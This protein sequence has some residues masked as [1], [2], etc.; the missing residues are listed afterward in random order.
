MTSTPLYDATLGEVLQRARERVAQVEQ[1]AAARVA[2]AEQ[3]ALNAERQAR[4]RQALV[5]EEVEERVRAALA[6]DAPPLPALQA[7]GDEPEP[8]EREAPPVPSME[9]LMRPTPG[10]TRFLD[11]LLG[12]PE[13]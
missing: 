9:E 11:A 10:I 3:R 6:L 2:Q 13:R 12:A 1:D 8:E 5:A 4:V 7:D